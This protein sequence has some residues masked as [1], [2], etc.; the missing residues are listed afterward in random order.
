VIERHY[1]AAGA[2]EVP[3]LAMLDAVLHRQADLIAQW[4][5]VGFIH[6]VMNTD[7]MSIA[8]ESIDFGPCAFM[9]AYHPST[10]FSSIDGQGRYAWANQPRIAHWNLAQL[11]QSLLPL[12]DGPPEQAA[13]TAQSVLNR[14]PAAFQAAYG[15]RFGAK[16]GLAALGEP[17]AGLMQDLLAM[18]ATDAVDFTQAF[19][20]LTRGLAAA[21]FGSFRALFGH[22][23]EID[24]WLEQWRAR[25]GK[26]PAETAIARMRGANPVVIPRNHRVEAALEAAIAGDIGVFENLLSAIATPFT[27]A[28]DLA[29]YETPPQPEEIV[30]ATYCGT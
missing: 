16:I 20:A 1:P 8:G 18:M 22:A 27:E 12:I 21:D 17:E 15:A 13:E 5:S 4:M 26:E 9:D 30:T 23:Q 3:A 2:A 6:G 29:D 14:F 28:R 25:V 11:A 19:T 24:V 10:V 7:N